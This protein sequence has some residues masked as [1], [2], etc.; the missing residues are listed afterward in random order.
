MELF[1]ISIGR[2]RLC[3]DGIG[4][5]I[6]SSVAAG[7]LDALDAITRDRLGSTRGQSVCA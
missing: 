3:G 1:T 4:T 2:N 6:H 5:R 7:L